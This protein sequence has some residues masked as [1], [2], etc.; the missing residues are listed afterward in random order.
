ML[1]SFQSPLLALSALTGLVLLCVPAPAAAAGV[2]PDERRLLPPA[3]LAPLWVELRESSAASPA[4]LSP[5]L[6]ERWQE[7]PQLERDMWL[8]R[9][10]NEPVEPADRRAALLVLGASGNNEALTRFGGLATSAFERSDEGI[11]ACVELVARDW[12]LRSPPALTGFP[13]LSDRLMPELRCALHAAVAKATPSHSLDYLTSRLGA[14]ADE[15]RVI[16][17]LI[18]AHARVPEEGPPARLLK[19]ARAALASPDVQ[20]RRE[21]ALALGRLEDPEAAFELAE[22][23]D[24]QEHGERQ[25]AAWALQRIT[26]LALAPESATWLGWLAAERAYWEESGEELLRQLPRLNRKQQAEALRELGR[27]PWRRA[28]IARALAPLLNCDDP[29]VARLTTCVLADLG[30]QVAAALLAAGTPRADEELSASLAAALQRVA[31]APRVS[32]RLVTVGARDSSRRGT[33]GR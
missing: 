1:V 33:D 3:E 9:C 7:R 4:L 6:V 16:L 10:A 18:G 27:H 13:T 19:R 20:L 8:E 26:G 28:D 17:G 30:G 12:L 24:S 25:A 23:F 31:P 15:D 2:R 11:E 21:A 32:R 14:S 29:Q 5:K 22:L